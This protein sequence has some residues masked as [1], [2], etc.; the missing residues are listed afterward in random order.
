MINLFREIRIVIARSRATRQSKAV[1]SALR[2]PRVLRTLAMTL[3]LSGFLYAAETQ[4]IEVHVSIAASKSLSVNTTS[5]DFGALAV[6]TSSVSANGLIVTNDSGAL[7]ETYTL[8]A[9]DAISDLGG[10][11]WTLASSTGPNQYALAAQFSNSRPNNNNVDWSNDDLSS[12]VQSCSATQFGNGTQNES[13]YQVSPTVGLNTRNL[14]FRIKTPDQVTDPG[15][16]T[17][18]VTL[19]VE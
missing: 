8:L 15:G 7:I 3:F 13:G 5:Y 4:P 14:W 6:N 17:A 12:S 1:D 2:L 16:H 18:T 9:G 19:A 11:D 10:Q